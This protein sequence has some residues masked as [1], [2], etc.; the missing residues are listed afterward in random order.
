MKDQ[1]FLHSTQRIIPFGGAANMVHPATGY[2]A[3][4]MLTS[5]KAFSEAVGMGLR[6]NYSPDKIATDA[7]KTLWSKQNRNQRDFQ[8]YG[9]DFLMHQVIQ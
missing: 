7:F 3:S 5:S 9:G 4:R 1:I 6:A 8:A 2:Q